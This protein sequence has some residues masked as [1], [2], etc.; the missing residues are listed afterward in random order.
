MKR[1]IYLVVFSVLFSACSGRAST[2]SQAEAVETAEASEVVK[3][4]FLAIPDDDDFTQQKRA[5]ILEGKTVTKKSVSMDDMVFTYQGDVRTGEKGNYAFCSLEEECGGNE[6]ITHCFFHDNG[7]EVTV[8]Y[9]ASHWNCEAIRITSKIQYYSYDISKSELKPVKAPFEA[10]AVNELIDAN[11]LTAPQQ[12]KLQEYIGKGILSYGSVGSEIRCALADVHKYD[13]EFEDGARMEAFLVG[14]RVW[15]GKTFGKAE[16]I[17]PVAEASN[18]QENHSETGITPELM[19]QIVLKIPVA[20]MPD[21]FDKAKLRNQ[22]KTAWEKER[23]EN[24]VFNDAMNNAMYWTFIRDTEKSVEENMRISFYQTTDGKKIVALLNLNGLHSNYSWNIKNGAYEYNV[25]TGKLAVIDLPAEPFAEDELIEHLFLSPEESQAWHDSFLKKPAIMYH[26]TDDG[27]EAT[28]DCLSDVKFR[29]M[30]ACLP[31]AYRKWNG[32]R[33]VKAVNEMNQR[34]YCDCIQENGFGPALLF[35]QPVPKKITGYTIKKEV[36]EMEGQE[37][38][39]YIIAKNGGKILEIDPDT[40]WDTNKETIGRITVY[41]DKYRANMLGVGDRVSDVF[42]RHPQ[43]GVHLRMDGTIAI[44]PYKNIHYLVD[45]NGYDG[46][47]PVI[48]SGEGASI[49]NPKFKPDAKINAV[50]VFKSI[51]N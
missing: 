9:T 20:G 30:S 27:F 7:N 51:K 45:A 19:W 23:E 5:D 12:R 4:I 21:G 16:P 40:D 10:F 46:K 48:E 14:R 1:V 17:S 32:N 43:A 31:S 15:N 24:A 3:A 50:Y 25:A 18:R 26:L 13:A 44:C 28:W 8:V 6:W 29:D 38:F 47:I 35:G 22:W 41:S 37:Q 33:F 11:K 2:Q 42:K 49:N 34:Y 36:C 39:T